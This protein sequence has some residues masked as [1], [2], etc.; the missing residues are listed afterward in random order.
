MLFLGAGGQVF[1][2]ARLTLVLWGED[3]ASAC[4]RI[5]GAGQ[6]AGF[7]HG[8]ASL[9]RARLNPFYGFSCHSRE[10]TPFAIL[11]AGGILAGIR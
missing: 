5:L 8:K 6:K 7:G 10:E 1:L 4:G 2:A 9:N 11:S 3:G